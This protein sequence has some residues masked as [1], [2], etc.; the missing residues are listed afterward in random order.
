MRATKARYW[1]LTKNTIAT[2]SIPYMRMASASP[3]F[4]WVSEDVELPE[5]K[6][7]KM[8]VPFGSSPRAIA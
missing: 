6:C 2:K 1:A 3:S 7:T 4:S 8:G 5:Q